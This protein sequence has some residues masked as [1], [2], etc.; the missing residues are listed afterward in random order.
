MPGNS[1]APNEPVYVAGFLTACVTVFT[2]DST[3]RVGLSGYPIRFLL[4]HATLG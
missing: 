2:G 3:F 1:G 4:F